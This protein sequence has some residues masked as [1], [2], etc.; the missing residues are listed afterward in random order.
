MHT[1]V[2]MYIHTYNR[3]QGS[4]YAHCWLA[5]ARRR[6]GRYWLSQPG[7]PNKFDCGGDFSAVVAVN[8][9]HLRVWVNQKYLRVYVCACECD[10]AS[11]AGFGDD[12]HDDDTNDAA[13]DDVLLLRCVVDDAFVGPK[14]EP[15]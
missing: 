10:A 12:D 8:G 14:A 6:H 4:S 1:Y 3:A 5:T 2:H 13:D 15:K 7:V 11:A 9:A